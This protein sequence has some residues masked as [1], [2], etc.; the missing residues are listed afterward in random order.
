MRLR[1]LVLCVLL[2]LAVAYYVYTPLPE[3]IQ[4]PWKLMVVSAGLRTSL[5]LVRGTQVCVFVCSL[6]VH[7]TLYNGN[8]SSLCTK[9][10]DKD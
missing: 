7:T 3:N 6:V 5:H 8:V 1:P 4:E 9:G 10:T 2:A